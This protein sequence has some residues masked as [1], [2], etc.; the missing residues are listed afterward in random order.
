MR[1]L[2]VG[3][4]GSPAS[5][6]ALRWAAATAKDSRDILTVVHVRHIPGVWA[7]YP[8]V[9]RAAGPYLD[10]LEDQARE[11]SAKVLADA[12]LPPSFE[13]R[14]GDAAAE[15]ESAAEEHHADVIVVSGHGHRGFDRLL[16]GSVSSRLVHTACVP[17]L[18]VR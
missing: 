8:S 14:D 2:I 13:V 5:I 11:A 1:Q 10:E 6:E 16:L 9:F 7:E 3:V 15:L 17:V 4:D 12:G 18:V